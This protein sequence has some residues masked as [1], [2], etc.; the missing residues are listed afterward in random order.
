MKVWLENE[1]RL[2][3][4]KITTVSTLKPYFLLKKIERFAITLTPNKPPG[5]IA[6][7]KNLAKLFCNQL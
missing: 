6:T 4:G 1:C 5:G 7:T 3:N 2:S